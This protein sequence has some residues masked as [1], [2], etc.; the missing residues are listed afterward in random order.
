MEAGDHD[1]YMIKVDG[2]GRLTKR[3][4]KFLRA[5]K[6]ATMAIENS[7]VN[8]IPEQTITPEPMIN[9]DV[10]L[11]PEPHTVT[12]PNS[13]NTPTAPDAVA[14]QMSPPKVTRRTEEPTSTIKGSKVPAMLKRLLP[15]NSDGLSE[16]IVAPEG[17]RR[18]RINQNL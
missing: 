14:V 16:G 3:N 2:S 17:G 8:K 4:R 7:P 9:N 5:F 10:N 12:I 13:D 18:N 6:P 11:R 1:Q 15:F